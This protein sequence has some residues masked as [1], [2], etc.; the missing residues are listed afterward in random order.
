MTDFAPTSMGV[1]QRVH[2]AVDAERLRERPQYSI[3][4]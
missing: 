2:A 3:T 4:R 1:L